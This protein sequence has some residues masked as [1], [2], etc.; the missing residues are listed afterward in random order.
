MLELRLDGKPIV[1]GQAIFLK[2]ELTLLKEWPWGTKT[3]EAV[4]VYK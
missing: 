3:K 2:E 1:L 4:R